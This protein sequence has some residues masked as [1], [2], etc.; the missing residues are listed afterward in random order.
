MTGYA[1]REKGGIEGG[2][3]GLWV[4]EPPCV[5]LRLPRPPFASQKGEDGL[6]PFVLTLGHFPSSERGEPSLVGMQGMHQKGEGW[7][8]MAYR[9]MRLRFVG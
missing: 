3:L 6:P 7:L 2:S 8:G 9:I 5:S 4:Y 1:S